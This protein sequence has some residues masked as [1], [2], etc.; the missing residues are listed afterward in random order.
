MVSVLPTHR[1]NFTFKTIHFTMI[2]LI[3]ELI[4]KVLNLQYAHNN[5]LKNENIIRIQKWGP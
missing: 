3:L 2:F 5:L 4:P 1:E